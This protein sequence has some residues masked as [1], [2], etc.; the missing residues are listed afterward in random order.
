MGFVRTSLSIDT[1]R[2]HRKMRELTT[3][4]LH[5]NSNIHIFYQV[6]NDFNFYHLENINEKYLTDSGVRRPSL[7]L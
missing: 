4:D 6:L 5:T 1:M 3:D 2:H 7:D